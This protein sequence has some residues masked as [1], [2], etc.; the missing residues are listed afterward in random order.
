MSRRAPGVFGVRIG[1]LHLFA[2]GFSGVWL[3]TMSNDSR[4]CLFY[5]IRRSFFPSE[6]LDGFYGSGRKISRGEL[7]SGN[8]VASLFFEPT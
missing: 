3:V 8:T 1:M 7:V 6:S 5:P 4:V 2:P